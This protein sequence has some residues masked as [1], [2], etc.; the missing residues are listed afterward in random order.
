M[1][2]HIL[3]EGQTEEKFVNDTLCTYLGEQGIAT[4]VSC[5]TIKKTAYRSY[6]GG[7]PPFE[8]WKK[9]IGLF[10]KQSH[11]DCVTTM[12]DLYGLDTSFPE[13]EQAMRVTDFNHR[14]E[15]LEEAWRIA[16]DAVRFLPYIQLHEF[17]A[18]LFTDITKIAA[19]YPDTPSKNM[20]ELSKVAE[21]FSNP[22]EIDQGTQTAPSKR[23]IQQIPKYDNE[24]ASVGAKTAGAIGVEAMREKC[25]HFNTWIEAIIKRKT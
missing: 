13:Y 9:E 15:A 21:K 12:V 24:K 5:I 8:K 10:L 20:G 17:E 16:I 7:S 4:S 1:N 22:E 18:L 19:S 23:I 6:K 25:P 3:A 14:V 2:L 11:L